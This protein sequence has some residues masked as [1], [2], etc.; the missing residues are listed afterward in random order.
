MVTIYGPEELLNEIFMKVEV[1]KGDD[2]IFK[3]PV[4]L[5][6]VVRSDISMCAKGPE[7]I[8][9]SILHENQC[10]QLDD[11]CSKSLKIMLNSLALIYGFPFGGIR[12]V[13]KDRTIEES[14][15]VLTAITAV[16]HQHLF[17]T[18]PVFRC[19]LVFN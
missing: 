2:S 6:G 4:K 11:A 3:N 10:I 13:K 1:S 8:A 15:K 5:V 18:A 17:L 12:L 9:F 7:R 14:D 19:S 16:E